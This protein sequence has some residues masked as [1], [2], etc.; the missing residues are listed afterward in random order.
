MASGIFIEAQNALVSTIT[1]LGYTA[2]TDPRNIRPMSVLIS[3]PTFDSFTYNVGDITFTIS[4]VAAPP[5]N[6]D[7]VDYLL[8][9]VDVLMNSSLPITSGR[10]A[11]VTI[12]GQE[13]PA[14]DLTVRIASRRN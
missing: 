13:L 9:Q 2:I 11:V 5:A 7:A 14:Y 4:V 10:P 8:T 1:A 12:G 6:Q 3:P